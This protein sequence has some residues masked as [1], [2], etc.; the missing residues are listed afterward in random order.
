MLL[1]GY[2]YV[3]IENTLSRIDAQDRFKN[4]LIRFKY[5]EN[6]AL[7]LMK[8]LIWLELSGSKETIVYFM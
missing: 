6:N 5:L 1:V 4:I 7:D 3:P 8:H 2:L